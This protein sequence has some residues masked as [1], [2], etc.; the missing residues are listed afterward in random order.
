MA[1]SGFWRGRRVLLTGHTGFKGAWLSLWLERLGAEVCGLALPAETVPALAD[2]FGA[3][4]GSASALVD[5]RDAA[6]VARVVA[7]ARPEVVI[8]LAAQPLV[9]RSYADPAETFAV[10]VMGTVNLLEALRT[11]PGLLAVVVV[12]TDK[13]YENDGTGRTFSERDALGG[14]DPYSASK[15]CAE[16]VVRSFRS[17]FFRHGPALATARAGNV[18]GGGDVSADRLVPDAVRAIA[19]GQCLELR[20]PEAT[21]PWQ[22]VLEPL[23]GYLAL[24]QSL[25]EHPGDTPDAINFGPD[26]ADASPVARVVE[27]LAATLGAAL[28]WRSAPGPHPPE[29][30]ALAIVS[31]LAARTLGWHPRLSFAETI[32][33]TADWYRAQ[34]DGAD[35]RAVSLAQLA[36][37]EDLAPATAA[38]TGNPRGLAA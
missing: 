1:V 26:P 25:V 5:I 23:S 19:T 32:A 18:V 7:A 35:M 30:G 38:A 10:N 20:Y 37:Y 8:H 31:D 4:P 27:V 29:A 12:T 28:P 3:V 21:R 9:R 6:G 24:A 15:A 34:R 22:H 13:I 16:L 36:A 33:W 2:L 11:S 17:S 14:H